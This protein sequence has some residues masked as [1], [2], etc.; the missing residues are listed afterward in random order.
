MKYIGKLS[1]KDP[2]HA[3]LTDHIY[4]QITRKACSKLRVFSLSASNEVYVYENQHNVRVIG[5]FFKH[6]KQIAGL[7]NSE[8]EYNNLCYLNSLGITNHQ[9]RVIRPLGYNRDINN[10]LVEEYFHGSPLSD[11]IHKE[12]LYGGGELYYRLSRLAYFMA[13]LH[14][15]TAQKTVQLWHEIEYSHKVV[16]KLNRVGRLHGKHVSSLVDNWLSRDFMW[17]DKEVMLHGDSTPSNWMFNGDVLTA[18]DLERMRY[19]DRMYDVGMIIGEMQHMFRMYSGSR[20]NAEPF[21]TYF[22]K[23]YASHFPDRRATF[24][25]ITARLPFYTA[26]TLLRIARNHWISHAH[27][28]GLV[29]SAEKILRE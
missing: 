13:K 6:D 26:L 27:A 16:E 24:R 17:A 19:G 23:Q 12:A 8:R 18:I 15:T 7:N 22:L 9:Y 14:N 4:P 28:V 2:L 29:R 21:I 1:E 5:K 25:S 3:Y 11:Y 10:I 20:Y